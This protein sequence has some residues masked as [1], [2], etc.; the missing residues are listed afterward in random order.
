MV[1]ED[2]PARY[3]VVANVPTALGARTLAF[4]AE[5]HRIFLVTAQFG[6]LPDSTA[7][8]PRP[9]RPMVPGT[10]QLMVFGE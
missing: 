9:R 5:S 4:D 8:Q 3:S 1:H 2:S 10:F 7:A 6:P